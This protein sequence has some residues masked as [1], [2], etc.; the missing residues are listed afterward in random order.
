MRHHRLAL[1]QGG[2][3]LA[4]AGCPPT[5]LAEQQRC[6]WTQWGQGP[7]HRG[8]ACVPGQPPDRLL[9]RVTF[10]PFTAAEALE[11][12]VPGEQGVLTIHY[13]TPL[14]VDDEVYLVVKGGQFVP[15]EPPGSGSLADGGACGLDAKAGLTWSVKAYRWEGE[16]LTERWTYPTDWKPPGRYF[17]YWEPPLQPAVAGDFLWVPGVHGTLD[18]VRRSDG[19]R[20]RRVDPFEGTWNSPVEAAFAVSEMAVSAQGEV[21]QGVMFDFFTAYGVDDFR[22]GVLLQVSPD[23]GARTASYD[24]LVPEAPGGPNDRCHYGFSTRTFARPFPPV[25]DAG[26]FQVLMDALGA[27][28]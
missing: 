18:Q 27:S 15:C 21:Y 26:A 19:V 11:T 14:L 13:P 28:R 4:L 9:A 17:A 23:G 1:L 6:N 5:D 24:D 25:D 22:P 10:D 12:A 3:L 8:Q 20:V 7:A 2:F 16:K